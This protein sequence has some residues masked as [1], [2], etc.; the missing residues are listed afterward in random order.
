LLR[1]PQA[2]YPQRSI[3]QREYQRVQTSIQKAR[4]SISIF[5]I[6]APPILNRNR[7]AEIEFRRPLKG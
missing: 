2:D 6:V 1:S 7:R 3:S 4:A 5:A